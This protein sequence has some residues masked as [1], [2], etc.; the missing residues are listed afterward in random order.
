[1]VKTDKLRELGM[2]FYKLHNDNLNGILGAF[3]ENLCLDIDR[4][5]REM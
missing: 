5:L 2:K 1:M 4:R 3:G